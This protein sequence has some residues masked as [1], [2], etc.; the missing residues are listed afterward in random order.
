MKNCNQGE[1]IVSGV[2]VTSS[3]GQ[4]KSAFT[5]GLL[6]G[7]QKF[8]VMQRPGRQKP[9]SL[10]R[11]NDDEDQ[12]N[13]FLGAEISDFKIPEEIPRNILRTASYSAQVAL[14]TLDEAWREAKLTEFDPRRIGLIVGGSN[15]QQ[16]ELIQTYESF[17]E[18]IHFVRPTYAMNFMDSDLCGI[19]TD[20]FGIQG[21]A[22]TQGGASASGQL[23][24]LQAIQ[25][26]QSG[27]VDVCIAMGALMD[28]SYWE[29]QGFRSLG[30]MGSN[31]FSGEPDKACRPFDQNRDGFIYGESCGVVVIEKGGGEIRNGITPYARLSGW[32]VGMD[33]NRNPN[34]SFEGEV[35]VIQKA[36]VQANLQPGEIDYVNP[37][38][39]GSLIGDETELEALH[40]CKL[41]HAYINSTKSIV[42]HGLTAAGT[43]ECIATLLQMRK[44]QLHPSLNLQE[45]INRSFNWVYQK[46]I[47]HKISRALNLSMGFGGTN[48]AICLESY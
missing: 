33:G 43:V 37:H 3:I 13:L 24:I 10:E 6:D 34:P 14:A 36:L 35:N 26:V 25:A 23:A 22:F 41:N 31:R 47:N 32:A 27:Q 11:K 38:G 20:V 16:R 17:R 2:G 48:T 30:A 42:G 21:F 28:I 44:E 7:G 15:F 29:C 12:S 9:D 45:P 8:G 5:A 4:G 40:H 18:K 46:A 19:C 1:I 39:T